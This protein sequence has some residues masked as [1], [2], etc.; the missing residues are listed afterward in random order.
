MTAITD[1]VAIGEQRTVD[2]LRHQRDPA[3]FPLS[4]PA[5]SVIAIVGPTAVGKTRLSVIL[6]EE[7][8]G[9]IV[10]LDSRQMVRRLEI[11][12]AKPTAGERARVR[13]HLVDIVEPDE[14]LSIPAVQA[15]A[16]AA[17]ED[18]LARGRQP[19]V[20]GGTGQYV[21]AVVEGWTIPEVPPDEALRADL[22]AFAGE[23]GA[24]ALHARLAAIDPVAAA[25][26]DARNVRRVIR[27]LEVHAITGEPISAIQARAG[28]PYHWKIIG[29]TLPRE[30]L[31]ARIDARI[32]AMITD[33]LEEE[34]RGLVAAG[35]GFGLPAMSSVGYREWD[36]CLRG[37]I[38]V[39]S[40]I[41]LIRR[42]TRRL[43]RMQDAWFKRDDPRIRWVDVMDEGRAVEIV[44]EV[45][46]EGAWITD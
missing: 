5:S 39:E 4:Q 22:A 15:L 12:T 36:H 46:G 28:S 6:A 13:H 9:E 11:G 40:V 41:R 20:V 38:D 23:H 16:L 14:P 33:G 32:D 27:A 17:I 30:A 8:G 35:Y 7:V 42:D 34:V 43:V 18:I 29:L 2:T 1:A 44:R 31:Y 21:W 45:V 26:I 10:S 24:D 37:D 3:D 19:I 25:K